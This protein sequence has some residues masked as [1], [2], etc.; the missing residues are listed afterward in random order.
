MLLESNPGKKLKISYSK[1]IFSV[2]TFICLLFSLNVHAQGDLFINPK[3]IVFEGQ[4]HF[5]EINL[6][7]IG[8]DT[9]R[10]VISFIQIRM[11]EDGNFEQI[12]KPDSGQNFASKYLRIFPRMVTLA[13]KESQVVKVQVNQNSKLTDGEYRSHLYFRAVPKEIPLG[14]SVAK[15]S[16]AKGVSV[17]LTPVYG[18][19]IP[20]IIRI[21]EDNTKV[22]LS[23]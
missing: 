8:K 3:R 9:A 20:V 7:N 5:Q 15:D 10:Y 12:E 23:D 18:I 11:K 14:E 17:K 16:T 6:A 22:T 1:I 13:P 19:S 4:K 21:G 2:L